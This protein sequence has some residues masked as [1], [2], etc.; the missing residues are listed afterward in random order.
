MT[1]NVYVDTSALAKWYLNEAR[2]EDVES[3]IQTNSPISI[4]TLTV[5]EMRSLLYRRR[6]AKEINSRIEMQVMAVFEE[7]IRKGF[8]VRH[9]LNDYTVASAANL[10][11]MVGNVALKTLDSLHL[12]IARDIGASILATSDRI[13]AQAG[14]A[15]GFAVE[16]FWEG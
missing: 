11:P 14:I 10:I 9:P 8:L 2:S 4:S 15:L 6:R 7:D 13:M 12:A 5:V 3:Y 16:S 1:A